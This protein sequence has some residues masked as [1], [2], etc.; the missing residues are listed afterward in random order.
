MSDGDDQRPEVH[1]SDPWQQQAGEARAPATGQPASQ[2][3]LNPEAMPAQFSLRALL[4]MTAGFSVLFAVLHLLGIDASGTIMAFLGSL[5]GAGLAI[6]IVDLCRF[7]RFRT[8]AGLSPLGRMPSPS[9][10]SKTCPQCGEAIA[11]WADR[12]FACGWTSAPTKLT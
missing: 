7:S 8:P 10:P 5:L 2:G 12:C 11:P 1:A 6:L 4:I 9:A 3:E